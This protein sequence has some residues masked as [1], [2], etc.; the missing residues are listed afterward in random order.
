M[1]LKYI[2]ALRKHFPGYCYREGA[3]SNLTL[4]LDPIKLSQNTTTAGCQFPEYL[5]RLRYPKINQTKSIHKKIEPEKR[6]THNS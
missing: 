6:Y 5:P 4:N 3:G 1:S 2:K